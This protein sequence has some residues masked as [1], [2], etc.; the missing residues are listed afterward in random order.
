VTG[1]IL[2]VEDDMSVQEATSL[3]L[4]RA[5]MCVTGVGDGRKALEMF[6]DRDFDV[7]VLDLML[8]SIDGLTV[9]REIRRTSRIPIVILTARTDPNEVVAGLECGADDYVTK[10]FNGPE[11]LARVRAALRRAAPDDPRP[12]LQVGSLHIDSAAFRVTDNGRPLDLSVTEFRLLVELAR[13]PDR[14]LTREALVERVWGYAY[15]G[16]S[17]LVDMAIK[18]LRSKIGDDPHDPRYIETVRGVG[19]RFIAPAGPAD[20]DRIRTE[21]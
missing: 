5:G 1:N 14:V 19:Y 9:C 18:R 6:A 4:E 10:P 3:L 8:P 15:L 13:R 20:Q 11:L 17:R 2:L 7:V 21:L 12:A 16:D